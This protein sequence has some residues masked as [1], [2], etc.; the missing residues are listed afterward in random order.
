M[1]IT[2]KN[3]FFKKENKQNMKKLHFVVQKNNF[4][5]NIF[6]LKDIKSY[7][8]WILSANNFGGNLTA[9]KPVE[10]DKITILNVKGGV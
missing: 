7:Q 4:F 2:L 5:N 8:F 6:L 10:K 3:S 9:L 1:W